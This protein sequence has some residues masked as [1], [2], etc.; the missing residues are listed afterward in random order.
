MRREIIYAQLNNP[1]RGIADINR[2]SCNRHADT[3]MRKYYQAALLI[4]AVISLTALLF[5]R[6]EYNRLRYVLEVFN[7]FGKPNQEG[8]KISCPQ[9]TPELKKFSPDLN[10]PLSSWQRLD[11]DLFIY[12]SYVISNKKIQTISYGKLNSP[13]LDCNIFFDDLLT[14]IPGI[15]S[16]VVLG[17]TSDIPGKVAYRGYML[18]C[19]YTEN[20]T[21]VGVAY[22]HRY[23]IL[24]NANSPI[25]P[26]KK[27]AKTLMYNSSAL[28]VAPP[29][30]I[31]ISRADM[32]SFLNFHELVG[33]NHFVIYDYGIPNAFHK[34]LKKM[35]EDSSPQWNFTY[36]VVPWNFPIREIHPNIIRNIIETDCLFRTYNKVMYAATISWEEYIV[37]KYHDHVVSD[38]L[39]DYEKTKIFGN[40]YMIHTQTFCTQQRD[41]KRSTNSTPIILRKIY[42]SPNALDANFL[43]IYKPHE[44]VNVRSI[45]T[46]KAAETL[47]VLNRYVLCNDYNANN[48]ESNKYESSIL[49]FAGYIKDSPIHKRYVSGKMFNLE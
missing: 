19:E 39:H 34:A 21:P 1:Q 32:I 26:V 3:R 49:R 7:Y 29:L 5:Y 33:M 47:I 31:P 38:L 18:T 40:R 13:N 25:L 23:Q 37:L 45:Q 9:N 20:M 11:D 17:N 24:Y 2:S 35:I 27:Q 44:S 41:D 30:N 10:E 4:T 48:V 42:T 8:I 28:C 6:H 12:S 16:F 15:F 36:E 46:L 43:Y 14:P 22:Q